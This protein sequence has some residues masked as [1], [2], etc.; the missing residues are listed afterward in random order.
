ML[1]KPSVAG[2]FYPGDKKDCVSMIDEI[3]SFSPEIS[4]TGNI[5]AAIVPHA[6]WVYSGPTAA[7]VFLSLDRENPPD[8][9]VFLGAVH[10]YGVD[11]PSV[12][13]QGA[14]ETPLGNAEI[15]TELAS[16]VLSGLS[17]MVMDNPKAHA[18]EHS[19]EVNIP[20][21]LHMFPAAKILPIACPP[22]ASS[23]ELGLKLGKIIASCNKK[24]VVIASTDLTHYGPSY[25][26]APRGVGKKAEEWVK[27]ENDAK[28][29][30]MAL[31]F[32]GESI[33]PYTS[34]SHS[35][36][37]GGAVACVIGCAKSL[38]AKN[39]KLLEYTNSLEMVP[40]FRRGNDFV[41]YCSIIYT[42]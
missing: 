15:D 17:G 32:N 1:R 42:T 5:V 19:I 29:L 21:V 14:W 9:F 31:D 6:G 26:F 34:I 12:Y 20:F 8:T 27:E 23:Y 7:K 10:R 3:L 13:P 33:V 41:G 16:L 37:G 25:G 22:L 39:S 24:V 30:Q 36:C 4:S 38:G 40:E 2:Q 35:A 28:L 18:N 11:Q